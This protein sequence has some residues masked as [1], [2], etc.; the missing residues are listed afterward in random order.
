M[1][2]LLQA[3]NPDMINTGLNVLGVLVPVAWLLRLEN[4]LTKIEMR[5]QFAIQRIEDKAHLREV[6]NNERLGRNALE[7]S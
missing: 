1:T 5:I 2:I 4:R 3:L 6:R 7:D